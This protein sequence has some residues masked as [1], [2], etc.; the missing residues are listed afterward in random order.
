MPAAADLAAILAR[1]CHCEQWQRD[2]GQYIPHPATWLNQGR[3][4]DEIEPT[5]GT[6]M[7]YPEGW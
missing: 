2:G 1:Q 4:K 5:A 3:W 7:T 6:G